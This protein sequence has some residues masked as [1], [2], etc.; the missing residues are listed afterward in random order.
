MLKIDSKKF[1]FSFV[2]N[3]RKKVASLEEG[4]RLYGG[5]TKFDDGVYSNFSDDN[6]DFIKVDN[7]KNNISIFIPSTLNVN[8]HID[9][10][11]YVNYSYNYI[12]KIYNNVSVK[13]YNTVGSWYSEDL[14][15]VVI[16]NITIITLELNTI[17]ETDI[18]NFVNLAAWIKQ[19]MQQESVSIA[20]NSALAIV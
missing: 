6:S 1:N 15:K 19:E 14:K 5:A 9:N 18:I 8:E 13:Y 11:Y 17:T 7:N 4:A 10:S 20:I 3:N 2:L 12:K 16:E